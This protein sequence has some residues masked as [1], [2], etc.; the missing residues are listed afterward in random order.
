[1]WRAR[2]LAAAG[3]VIVATAGSMAMASGDTSEGALLVRLSGYQEDP[4]ALSTT[5]VGDFR[6]RIDE[7]QQVI[8]YEL[9]YSDLEATVTQAHIHLGG[10]AQ[11]GGISVF[12]CS[13]LGNG[14][15]GTQACP[16]AP[17]T[18][19]GTLRPGD[20]IGPAGQGISAGE[21]A[22]L[23]AAIRSGTTYV[24]VHSTKYPG[25]EIRAQ[26]DHEH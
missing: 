26:L 21:F 19:T 3:L 17:A 20:V 15:V 6:A 18:I 1:M 22:E 7:V 16:P 4:N 23:L 14:P 11:N 9:S 8:E 24:N 2:V 10:R 25:G 5:G 12:L 13:N